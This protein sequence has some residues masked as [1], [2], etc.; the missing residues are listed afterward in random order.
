M[1]RKIRQT[2]LK[3]YGIWEYV[4]FGIGLIFLGRVGY[5]VIILDF[6]EAT[7]VYVGVL[8][9]F[10]CLGILSVAAPKSI[11]DFARKRVGMEVKTRGDGGSV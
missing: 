3:E 10:L 6:K 1:T 4:L 2:F 5:E 9:L 8:V 7:W 11:L